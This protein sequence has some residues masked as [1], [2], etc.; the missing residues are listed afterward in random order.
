[1]LKVLSVLASLSLVSLAALSVAHADE[2]IKPTQPIQ[3]VTPD[4]GVAIYADTCSNGANS[5]DD[6]TV[7]EFIALM[8][9]NPK[10]KLYQLEQKAKAAAHARFPDYELTYVWVSSAIPAAHV[11]L[12]CA[13]TYNKLIATVQTEVG[14][15]NSHFAETHFLVII[16]DTVEGGKR[17]LELTE[18]K[19][20]R[21]KSDQE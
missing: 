16:K 6:Q 5:S 15:T 13:T 14:P 9:K 20:L 2:E 8:E 18:S 10:S 3:L 7:R 21:I 1:M 4:Q 17:T 12:G 11:R 19:P